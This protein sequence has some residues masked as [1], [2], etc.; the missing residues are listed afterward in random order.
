MFRR[1]DA[2]HLQELA[3][4]EVRLIVFHR[5]FSSDRRGMLESSAAS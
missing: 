5:R 2:L 4:L 1:L 3:W